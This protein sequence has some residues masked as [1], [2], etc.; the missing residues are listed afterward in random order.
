[1]A[2]CEGRTGFAMLLLD[3]GANVNAGDVYNRTPLYL[4]AWNGHT[5]VA[6][7]LIDRGANVNAETEK[8][9]TPLHVAKYAGRK[10]AARLLIERGADPSKAFDDLGAI[11]DF[12]DGDISWMPEELKGK[13]GKRIRSRGAFGRF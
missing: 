13:L 7:I 6:R 3:R 5:E 4:A 11:I 2:A 9:W 8:K 10:R 1:M 12:F